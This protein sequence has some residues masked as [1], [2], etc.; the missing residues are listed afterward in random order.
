MIGD[1]YEADIL[2]ARQLG[3]N[4]VWITRRLHP[5]SGNFTKREE[6]IVS[7]LSEIPALLSK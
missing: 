7:K 5:P 1:N 4:T 3:M 6:E 2:G